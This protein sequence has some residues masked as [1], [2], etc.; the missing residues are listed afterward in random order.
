MI[1]EGFKKSITKVIEQDPNEF[2][3]ESRTSLFQ[4]IKPKEGD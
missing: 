1:E 4:I 2:E 3:F